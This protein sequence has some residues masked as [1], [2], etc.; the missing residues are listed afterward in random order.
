MGCI[1]E[2]GAI[3]RPD[4]G[5]IG[6]GRSSLVKWTRNGFVFHRHSRAQALLTN[7]IHH[8]PVACHVA[9]SGLPDPLGDRRREEKELRL[10][11]RRVWR[12]GRRRRKRRRRRRRG[13]RRRRRRRRRKRRRRRRRKRRR[14]RRR[15]EGT[16]QKSDLQHAHYTHAR[17]HAGRHTCAQTQT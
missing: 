3:H 2:S 15:K 14:R 6:N 9:I 7:Q 17:T 1:H 11:L 16:N 13:R 12:R 5:D 4:L 10:G 8:S